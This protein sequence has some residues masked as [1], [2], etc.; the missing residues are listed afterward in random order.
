MIRTLQ[1][2]LLAVLLGSGAELLAAPAKRPNLVILVAD[3]VGW[4]DVG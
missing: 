3:D 1:F 2:I 4:N